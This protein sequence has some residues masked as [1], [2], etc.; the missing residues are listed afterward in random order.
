MKTVFCWPDHIGHQG[1]LPIAAY[2]YAFRQ[3]HISAVLYPKHPDQLKGAKDFDCFLDY[4]GHQGTMPIEQS[5]SVDNL[6]VSLVPHAV[7]TAWE[8]KMIKISWIKCYKMYLLQLYSIVLNHL[9]YLSKNVNDHPFELFISVF[10]IKVL[11]I[12]FS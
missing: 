9:T 2:G 1:T 12:F 10:C 4:K 3:S 5:S 7:N 11:T 6:T 8:C